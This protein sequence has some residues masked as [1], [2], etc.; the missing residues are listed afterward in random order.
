MG[1]NAKKIKLN[2]LCLIIQT[3]FSLMIN[4]CSITVI[5]QIKLILTLKELKNCSQLNKLCKTDLENQRFCINKI[6]KL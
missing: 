3:L 4:L 2:A 6:K 5:L 1:I